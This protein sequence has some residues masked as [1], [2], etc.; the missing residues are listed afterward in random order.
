MKTLNDC[1]IERLEKLYS[2]YID[3]AFNGLMTAY[4]CRDITCHRKISECAVNFEEE[5]FLS[6][7][8]GICNEKGNILVVGE[9]PST[10]N[11]AGVLIGGN[12][13][14]VGKPGNIFS[15][16]IS[17]VDW[18]R[19]FVKNK[20]NTVPFFV[21]AIKCGINRQKDNNRYKLKLRESCVEEL[22]I[23]EIEILNPIIILCVGGSAYR[24]TKKAIKRHGNPGSLYNVVPLLHYS[25][26]NNSIHHNK[27]EI[28]REI[29]NKEIALKCVLI[30]SKKKQILSHSG[31][32]T[33]CS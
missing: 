5:A 1:V 19:E 9:A 20:Y 27:Y 2:S 8:M 16:N 3:E 17:H 12:F 24:L 26:R 7:F 18:I 10:V 21:D 28:I 4:K 13:E 25:Q 33:D 15:V 22:L 32:N 30:K 23:K 14:D 31:I 6:P 29:W 11:G